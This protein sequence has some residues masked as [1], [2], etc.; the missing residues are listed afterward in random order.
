MLHMIY[1]CVCV[2]VYFLISRN[3][4]N[5]Y[6]F[7]LFQTELNNVFLQTEH[8]ILEIF[9]IC[10]RGYFCPHIKEEIFNQILQYCKFS[11]YIH[12]LSGIPSLIRDI[13]DRK[14]FECDA[15]WSTS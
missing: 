15:R 13:E 7:C 4:V 3:I 14:K 12:F 11:N 9:L 10:I 5:L 6:L 8:N 1:I 2:Y